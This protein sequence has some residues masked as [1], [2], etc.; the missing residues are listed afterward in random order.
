M[1]PGETA[2]GIFF[3]SIMRNWMPVFNQ[4]FNVPAYYKGI[5]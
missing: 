3:N 1:L 4:V 2:G 5:F